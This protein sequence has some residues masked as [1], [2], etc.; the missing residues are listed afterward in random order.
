MSDPGKTSKVMK[1]IYTQPTV[2]GDCEMK[3]ERAFLAGSVVDSMG[4]ETAGQQNGGF[5][6]ATQTG[7]SDDTF[8]H[9]WG[10]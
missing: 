3:L 7:G 8:N 9:T 6:D 5:Y 10:D 1:Q 4:V 2:I